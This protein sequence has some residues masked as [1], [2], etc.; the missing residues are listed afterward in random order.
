MKYSPVLGLTI[1][2]LTIPSKTIFFTTAYSAEIT[3]LPYCVIFLINSGCF[4][5]AHLS[6]ITL[7]PYFSSELNNESM[8]MLR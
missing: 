5:M 4:R 3:V 2:T 6:F 8:F 7:A 1:S